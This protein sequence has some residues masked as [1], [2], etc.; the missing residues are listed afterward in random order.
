V[1]VEIICVSAGVDEMAI[2][3]VVPVTQISHVRGKTA[4]LAGLQGSTVETALRHV[5]FLTGPEVV[6][7]T[8]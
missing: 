1:E 2:F 3:A 8:L 6:A 5:A 4:A 7:E